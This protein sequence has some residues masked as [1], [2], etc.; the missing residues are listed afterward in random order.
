MKRTTT[1]RH[2]TITGLSRQ[3]PPVATRS[4]PFAASLRRA[5]SSS[6]SDSDRKDDDKPKDRDSDDDDKKDDS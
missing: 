6:D 5:D 2:T 4:R 3:A 1:I